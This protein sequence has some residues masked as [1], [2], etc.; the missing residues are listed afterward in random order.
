VWLPTLQRHR[1]PPWKWI[2]IFYG[3][4]TNQLLEYILSTQKIT[5]KMFT[6]MKTPNLTLSL[7]SSLNIST[8]TGKLLTTRTVWT[9]ISSYRTRRFVPIPTELRVASPHKREVLQI[10][11][12][13][14]DVM[15]FLF[16]RYKIHTDIFPVQE[17]IMRKFFGSS[18]PPVTEAER[19]MS[20]LI[21]S[22]NSV[23]N[24]PIPLM[25]SVV[26]V[27]S[28]HVKATTDLLPKVRNRQSVFFLHTICC[29]I[30]PSM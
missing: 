20:L 24:Y 29:P 18:P 23:F 1:L 9:K 13:E 12:Q 22:S 4:V 21:L 3:D 10:F 26:T 27:H 15:T 28:L 30:C 7:C 16:D 6:A 11:Q 8:W 25:P 14:S 2:C 5:T 17:A 19:N